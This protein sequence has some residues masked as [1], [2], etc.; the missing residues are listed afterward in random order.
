VS[1]FTDRVDQIVSGT[2]YPAICAVRDRTDLLFE[3]FVKT[4]RLSLMWAVPFGV[5]VALFADDL[6]AFA[7]GER[8]RDAV[9]LLQAFGVI[10]ALAHLGF[11]WDGYFRARGETRPMAV[12]GLAVLI[13]FL[14][15][16]LPLLFVYDLDGL[17][18]GLAVAAAAGLAVRWFYLRRLFPAFRLLPHAARAIAPTLPAAAL[19]LSAR[20]LEGGERTAFMAVAELV[21][22]LA[23]AVAATL[24][25]E[26]ALLREAV[27]YLRGGLRH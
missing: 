4:N 12:H 10:A 16:G 21:G 20:A 1:Q 5:G 23:V 27:G 3:T 15:A 8:W 13:A 11:N 24:W 17:A 19:V 25:L 6:V 14:A 26:R 18:A 7:I 9:P 2:L 22:Y